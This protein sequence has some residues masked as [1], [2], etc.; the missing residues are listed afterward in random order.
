MEG[1]APLDRLISTNVDPTNKTG[2]SWQSG[3]TTSQPN[4]YW[5]DLEIKIGAEAAE[6]N[7]DNDNNDNNNNDKAEEVYSL[8]TLRVC[9]GKNR[10]NYILRLVTEMKS[11]TNGTGTMTIDISSILPCNMTIDGHRETFNQTL[12]QTFDYLYDKMFPET[13]ENQVDQFVIAKALEIDSLQLLC[14]EHF[15]RMDMKS[16]IENLQAIT[17]YSTQPYATSLQPLLEACTNLLSDNLIHLET[18]MAHS[19]SHLPTRYIQLIFIKAVLK[20]NDSFVVSSAV[21]RV[22]RHNDAF[23]SCLSEYMV[24]VNNIDALLVKNLTDK[25]F[26]PQEDMAKKLNQL[27]LPFLNEENLCATFSQ[28][29]DDSHRCSYDQ[30]LL[31]LDR[32]DLCANS[33]DE[34][35][36]AVINFVNER[37]EDVGEE[38]CSALFATVRYTHLSASN[39]LLTLDYQQIPKQWL[40]LA[41][42][43]AAMLQQEGGMNSLNDFCTERIRISKFKRKRSATIDEKMI[44]MNAAKLEVKR[45]TPRISYYQNG[46][47]LVDHEDKEENED[48]VAAIVFDDDEKDPE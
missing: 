20:Q 46:K 18:S 19:V 4:I 21:C 31:L 22:C 7:N 32:D 6:D 17:T 42:V 38:A 41:Y 13:M 23:F 28:W 16:A 36:D 39:V 47:R 3:S 40:S 37:G 34:V 44:S 9:H 1:S 48:R 35:F 10:S 33:E 5:Y 43:G 2:D 29:T 26:E 30:L 14:V 12:H 15:K 25:L 8:H 45:L 27:C 24:V 11:H